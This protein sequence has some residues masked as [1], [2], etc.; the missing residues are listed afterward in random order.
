MQDNINTRKS[1]YVW[2]LLVLAVG[3]MLGMV[4]LYFISGIKFD[5]S[6]EIERARKLG[7]VSITVL[8]GY[9][10]SRDV[11]TYASVLFIP[12]IFSLA[13][14]LAW[15]RGDRR[16]TLKDFYE[17]NNYRQPINRLTISW[18]TGL[19]A[20][21][22]LAVLFSFNINLFY[23]PGY[24]N[25]V[26]AWPLLGEEGECLAWADSILR[27]GNQGKDFFCLYGPMLIY[28]LAWF[29]KLFG[30]TVIVERIYKYVLDILAYVIIIL[31]LFK[32]LR[33]RIIFIASSVLMILLFAQH[34]VS[35]NTTYLRM[36]LGIAP[37]LLAYLSL[38]K[39]KPYCIIASGAVAAQSLLFSQ[40][41]GA[42]SSIAVMVILI[43]RN[44]L[45][46]D[47]RKMARDV[48]WFVTGLVV[49]VAPMSIYF[50]SAGAA[51]EMYR[52]LFEYPS[53]VILGFG[54][55]PFTDFLSFL[56][57]PFGHENFSYYSVIFIYIL[58]SIYMI[59][60][61]SLGRKDRKL[62]L[63]GALLLFGV[64]LYRS[65][66]GR[67]SGLYLLRASIPA[68]LILFILI[69]SSIE[70]FI[71]V[72]S[73]MARVESSAKVALIV[74]LL[75][76][77]IFKSPIFNA[78]IKA[79]FR[80]FPDI[81]KKWTLERGLRIDSLQ[82]A[83]IFF[84]DT[85]AL[86]IFSINGFLSRHTSP[87]DYVYFFPN[88]PAYYFLFDRKMP[89]PFAQSYFA[90]TFDMQRHLTEYLEKNR[91][92]F[93]IYSKR[94]WRPDNIPEAVQ[95]PIV[96]QYIKESYTFLRNMGDINVLKRS[97]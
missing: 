30:D 25:A 54:G 93:V 11:L 20:A 77:M 24:N 36:A 53:Y 96:D 18:M 79:S 28:P 83:G 97:R 95:I 72:N 34:S 5:F 86:S 9:P 21:L 89:T 70:R 39:G 49:S 46:N 12:V 1:I 4:V 32:T 56:S 50:I 68:F 31:F 35:P 43:A 14:W 94:T 64:L 19:V 16:N 23:M 55:L 67:T 91:P 76:L 26:G 22:A 75:M 27:G 74:A 47:F 13:P 80:D 10:K 78:G 62:L 7:I 52:N 33:S 81:S 82:R 85:T 48:I 29:M 17:I 40:E 60:M 38:D 65:V 90:I 84:D 69:D 87:D 73:I 63:L 57:N 6:E 71:S 59:V 42:C 58:S 66:L 92:E 61:L 2:H 37:L 8:N 3:F 44:M 15:A 41:T 51:T 45:Y 88:E